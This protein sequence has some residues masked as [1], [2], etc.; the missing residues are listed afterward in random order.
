MQQLFQDSMAIVR[1]FSAILI[2]LWEKVV[3][4]PKLNIERAQMKVYGIQ[5]EGYGRIVLE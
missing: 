3:R 5:V 2:A 4:W 1:H